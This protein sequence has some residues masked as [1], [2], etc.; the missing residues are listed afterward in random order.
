M[1]HVDINTLRE[2]GRR[3]DPVHEHCNLDNKRWISPATARRL[4]CDTSLITVL[5]DEGGKV[6]NIGRRT[7]T[8]PSS[9]GRALSLRDPT[10]RF[11]GCCE[12]RYV[13]AHHIRHWAD[14]GE[15]SLGN[16]VTL[17]RYHHRKLHEGAFG[18]TVNK[19]EKGIQLAFSTP[20]GN[21]I[22]HSVFPQ[23][24]SVPAET[25]N[26]YLSKLAP[27]VH[28]GTAVS[29]WQGEDCDYGIAIDALLRRDLG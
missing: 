13:D 28:S 26:E 1:L 7:R 24:K 25:C 9:I 3:T 27:E 22:Q 18:I 5:E 23:F 4:S 21:S 20:S 29:R 12:S 11:P 2:Q 15:T 6:L 14:G 8:V 16:L 17:C 19:T 10:C